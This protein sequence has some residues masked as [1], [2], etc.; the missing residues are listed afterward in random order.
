MLN[1]DS[2]SYIIKYGSTGNKVLKYRFLKHP[3]SGLAPC[4]KKI[5]H[6]DPPFFWFK[7]FAD[8]KGNITTKF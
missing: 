5:I 8:A 3:E 2:F 7:H 1:C 4:S 6:G